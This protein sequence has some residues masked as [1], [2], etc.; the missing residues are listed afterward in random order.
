MDAPPIRPPPRRTARPA[1]PDLADEQETEEAPRLARAWHDADP[2]E[3]APVNDAP[4]VWRDDPE[5]D[6]DPITDDD[7]AA[8]EVEQALLVSRVG[9]LADRVRADPLWACLDE[10]RARRAR[11]R[12]RAGSWPPAQLRSAT[13]PPRD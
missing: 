7:R 2:C 5:D 10:L 12:R 11:E 8:E 9:G 3:G 4:L 13:I 1:A 6:D